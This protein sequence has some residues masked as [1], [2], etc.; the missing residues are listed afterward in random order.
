MAAGAGE[1][2]AQIP[3]PSA[4]RSP[5]GRH[6]AAQVPVP[7]QAALGELGLGTSPGGVQIARAGPHEV[8]ESRE[9]G[10]IDHHDV[11]E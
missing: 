5:D 1:D 9:R 7:R 3:I 8:L 2:V 6:C 10:R 4:E 11:G